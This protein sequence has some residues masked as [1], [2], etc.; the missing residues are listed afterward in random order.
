M[1]HPRLSRIPAPHNR[2]NSQR[3]LHGGT[4][5]G[6]RKGRSR[7]VPGPV[8]LPHRRH[9]FRGQGED[10]RCDDSDRGIS[11][12]YSVK[13]IGEIHDKG[14]KSL[15]QLRGSPVRVLHLEPLY[16]FGWSSR[17][18]LFALLNPGASSTMLS[19]PF[20]FEGYANRDC[21]PF[22][23]LYD[24]PEAEE[25][26][27]GTLWWGGWLV[28]GGDDVG[29]GHGGDIFS[30]SASLAAIA[31]LLP[32]DK[33][34]RDQVV[35]CLRW[36]GFLGA[37]KA[38]VWVGVFL[39]ITASYPNANMSTKAPLLDTLCACLEELMRYEQGEQD[40]IVLQHRFGVQ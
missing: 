11:H 13:T 21:A 1:A 37:E 3:H 10:G 31:S 36:I 2:V 14:R 39:P 32:G 34:T 20:G 15:L 5:C 17:G 38:T 27:R 25:V 7:P 8:H 22:A 4:R 19:R 35:S 30:G 28:E 23:E 29:G 40:M 12:I 26:L 24:I 6:Y 33:N 18:D 16:K 9:P